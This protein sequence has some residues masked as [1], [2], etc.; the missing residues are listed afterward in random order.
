MKRAVSFALLL[1]LLVVVTIAGCLLACRT[2]RDLG[3][4]PVQ[5]GRTNLQSYTVKGVVHDLKADGQMLVVRH[6]EIPG[7]MTAMTMPFRVKVTNELSFVRAG[8]EITFRLLVTEDESWIDHVRK[9][10][11]R[12]PL[13]APPASALTTNTPIVEVNLLDA[14]STYVFT[15]EFGRALHLGEYQGNAIAFTFFFTRCPIP[16]YCPRL[17][18][19][20]VGA[21]ARL[22]SIP[23]APTNWHLFSISFDPEFD[24]PALLR[25]YGRIYGY[26]SNRWSFLT[27][28]PETIREIT[29]RFGFNVRKSGNG[30][31]HNFLTLVLNAK[32]VMQ[33]A[34]PIGG[35]TTDNLV[36]EILKAA[37]S[38]NTPP[39]D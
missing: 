5:R 35:D 30:F 33:G 11:R 38:T 15:N 17:T 24:T 20:F 22:K 37:A 1:V 34:W 7:Y 8:D 9:T 6:E 12:L 32:G 29:G 36:A 10:G 4:P 16:E 13:D 18:K 25:S 39:R 19:N 2:Q 28:A 14:L 23:G 3:A 26:D 31:D 27:A 21:T